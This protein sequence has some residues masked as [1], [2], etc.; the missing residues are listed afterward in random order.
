MNFLAGQK[1]STMFI[2]ALIGSEEASRRSF[3]STCQHPK[4]AIAA[5][6]SLFAPPACPPTSIQL[7]PHLFYSVSA[8]SHALQAFEVANGRFDGSFTNAKFAS[9]PS[10]SSSPNIACCRYQNPHPLTPKTS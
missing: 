2:Q 1:V 10:L 3:V 9:S 4:E 6:Q 8:R 5:L 7:L